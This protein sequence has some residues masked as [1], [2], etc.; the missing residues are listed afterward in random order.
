MTNEGFA[1]LNEKRGEIYENI[2]L[3]TVTGLR[4]ALW[5][6]RIQKYKANLSEVVV[7][8]HYLLEVRHLPKNLAGIWNGTKT[9]KLLLFP[10]YH[11]Y[12]TWKRWSTKILVFPWSRSLTLLLFS[13]VQSYNRKIKRNKE[14]I[15]LLQNFTPK[16]SPRPCI[17]AFRENGWLI[18]FLIT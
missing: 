4:N 14:G 15:C 17:S 16:N 12:T 3:C 7:P 18:Y 5:V 9:I 10:P 11:C 8:L 2:R 13:L 1:P 6:L